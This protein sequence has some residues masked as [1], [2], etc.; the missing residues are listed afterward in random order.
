VNEDPP[1]GNEL[2]AFLW[3]MATLIASMEL[4]WLFFRHA[5]SP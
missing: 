3:V 2:T 4:V 1:P 5:L